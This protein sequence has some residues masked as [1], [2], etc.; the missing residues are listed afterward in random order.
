MKMLT[1]KPSAPWS[2][3]VCSA[4]SVLALSTGASGQ[5]SSREVKT[6]ELIEQFFR[7]PQ[8]SQASLSPDG[9][10][11]GVLVPRN[12]RVVLE[13]MNVKKSSAWV[14][15]S[16]G[17]ADVTG[18]EWINNHRLA[19]FVADLRSGSA[20]SCWC[21]FYAVNVDGAH[22]HSFGVRGKPMRYAASYDD[23]SD[24][25]LATTQE[26]DESVDAFQ[27]DTMTGGIR[28]LVYGV[29]HR[30]TKLTFDHKLQL[31]SLVV[32]S[33]NARRAA[34]WYRPSVDAPWTAWRF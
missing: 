7:H 8:F 34:M 30:A 3:I 16:F 1:G 23:G 9:T 20:E 21:G 25:V 27:L 17:N 5:D 33:S 2:R 11:M 31:R 4:A 28:S 18:F 24:D 26:Y 10:L 6:T 29:P 13:I 19:V 15:T 22:L 12:G 32:A 14:L